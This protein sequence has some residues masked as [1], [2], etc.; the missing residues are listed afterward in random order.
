MRPSQ[1][2]TTAKKPSSLTSVGG[3]EPRGQH[4]DRALV[5]LEEQPRLGAVVLEDGALRDLQLGGHVLDP[6]ALVAVL[7][8]VAHRAA[9]DQLAFRLG[10]R[11]PSS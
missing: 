8:E 1:Y 3:V 11:A 10:A 4:R 6:G 5:A 9:H 7:G 2:R